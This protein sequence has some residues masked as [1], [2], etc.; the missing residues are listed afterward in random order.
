MDSYYCWQKGDLIL[1]IKI[2]PNASKDEFAEILGNAIKIRISAPPVEGK[3][4]LHLL[5]FLAKQFKVR[6]SRVS[7]I[8]GK[9]ARLKRVKITAPGHTP[10]DDIVRQ[11]E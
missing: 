7:I 6:K 2:Q 4:N 5:N 3:A 9:T 8:S 10:V 11:P 1:N